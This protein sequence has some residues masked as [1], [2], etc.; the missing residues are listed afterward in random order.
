MK[1]N[2]LYDIAF[3]VVS[4]KEDGSDVDA[5]MLY[6]ALIKR[7]HDAFFNGEIVEACDGPVDTYEED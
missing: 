3:S 1:Y 6:R 4:G 5:E 2:H 7:A